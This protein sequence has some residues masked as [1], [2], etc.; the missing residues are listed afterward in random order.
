MPSWELLE[1]AVEAAEEMEEERVVT[2]GIVG[3]SYVYVC[4][5]RT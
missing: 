2:E 3:S 5:V 4:E 1:L